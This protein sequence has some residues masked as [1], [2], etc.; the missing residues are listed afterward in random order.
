VRVLLIATAYNGLCQR[1]HVE[2]EEHGHEVS[3]ALSLSDDEIRWA[4]QLFQPDLILCPF[5]KERVPEDIWRRHRCIIIH[6]G[7]K[8]DR[9]PSSLD[10]AITDDVAAWGVTALQAAEEMDAGAIWS[11][12]GF[13]MRAASKASLYRREVTEAAVAAIAGT[14]RHCETRGFVPEPLD[15]TRDDVRGT[16]RPTMK[17]AERAV[18]WAR[19]L[20]SDV[21][22]KIRAADS[23]PGVLD[24][25]GGAA[26]YLYGAH[27]EATLTGAPGAI[28]ARRHGA[29]CRATVDGAVWISHLKA[30][31]P[32]PG[33]PTFKL[34]AA[35]VLGDRLAGVP[36]VPVGLST[37]S[38]A[39][40]QEV[41]YEEANQVGYLHFD[42][43][44]GAMSTE[45]CHRLRDAYR[46]AAS[47]PVKVI[48]L[49]GG[50]D[51]WS[52]G[53][54]LNVIEAAPSAADES[55]RNINAIDDLVLEI[56]QTTS[57]LTV[58]ALWGSAGA[59]GAIVPLAA[60]RV[61]ARGGCIVNPHYKTMGL[62]GSEY[63]T[64]LLPRRIGPGL[65]IELTESTLP[66]GMQKARRIGL[67]DE[68]LPDRYEAYRAEVTARAEALM[69]SAEYDHLL[70]AKAA[71]RAADERIKPL[72]AYREAELRRMH[73][74][75]FDEDSDYHRLRRRFVHK[76]R[77]A[78]TGRCLARHRRFDHSNFPELRQP[79][80]A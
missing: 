60:D 67:V 38:A 45:Q 72:A 8:G 47:R 80:A 43:H 6:P 44:N 22:R 24:T 64:Y 42:F 26:Y 27:E 69:R 20:T 48:V 66:V 25:I 19:D 57:R 3:I 55:W 46:F 76:L 53:I 34:P 41:R 61:W 32:T 73:A 5:L 65:A 28:L 70:A 49:M 50:D 9:G 15:Y 77:P 13:P 56:L 33:A 59:G 71:A 39:T 79:T 74:Q 18:D 30:K 58:S 52:N 21:L 40:F 10:W 35:M 1:A 63:W 14:I 23:A 17:Q 16:L 78:E 51:F 29:I 62:Y 68:V 75:F 4:V 7:I 12:V 36:E 37:S 11:S 2:L 54:H 31:A